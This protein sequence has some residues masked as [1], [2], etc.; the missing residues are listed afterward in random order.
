MEISMAFISVKGLCVLSFFMRR[1][2]LE[3]E[4]RRRY[5]INTPFILKHVLLSPSNLYT[6]R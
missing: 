4:G 1:N 3:V 5:I 6:H 2:E